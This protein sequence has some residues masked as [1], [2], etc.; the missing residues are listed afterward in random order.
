LIDHHDLIVFREKEKKLLEQS[1]HLKWLEERERKKEEAQVASRQQMRERPSPAKTSHSEM[2][3]DSPSLTDQLNIDVTTEEVPETK[4]T[5]SNNVTPVAATP[6]PSSPL[7]TSLLRS[8]TSSTGPPSA[9]KSLS[10]P[11]STKLNL[12]LSTSIEI[13]NQKET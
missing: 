11:V 8:P 10:S 9:T 2:E 13:H 5:S 6:T 1:A 7:L 4:P 12:S 3:P